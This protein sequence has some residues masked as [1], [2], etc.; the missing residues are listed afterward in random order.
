[1]NHSGIKKVAFHTLGC[2]LNFTETSEMTRMLDKSRYEIVSFNEVADIYVINTCTVTSNAD[3]KSNFSINKAVSLNPDA[4]IIVTGCYSQLNSIKLQENKHVD[5]I[6]GNSQKSEILNYIESNQ[7]NQLIACEEDNTKSFFSSYSMGERTRAFVKI[8]DGCDYHCSY[9]TV[10]LARGK[11]RN[12]A[13]HEVENIVKT[14]AENGVKEIVLSGINLGDYGKSSGESFLQLLKSL[15]NK[16]D[17]LR[18]RISSIEPN[19]LTNEIIEFVAGS[20]RFVPHFHIPLQSGSD[21]ILELMK[22]R[23]STKLFAD[24][25]NKIKELLPDAGIG[26]DVITG[27][28]GE[29]DEDFADTFE[30]LNNLKLSYLHVF[31]FSPRPNTPA[32][33]FNNKIPSKLKN[34]RSKILHELSAELNNRFLSE[35]AG[36]LNDV[37]F[38]NF[39]D[40]GNI[41]GY[42]GNYIRVTHIYNKNLLNKVIN[43]ELYLSGNQAKIKI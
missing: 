15:D 1:M 43:G 35:N 4:K 16:E 24:L 8:Q 28:P 32:F 27:F 5:I 20:K 25:I 11:S 39:N 40:K 37:L 10:P 31:T 29:T 12:I 21:K 7:E 18:F 9:C 26:A 6:I 33:N 30:F 42:T 23:Y 34:K 13:I 36:K 2:K 41:H 14:I 38:E 17:I 3:R 22:R 19:L